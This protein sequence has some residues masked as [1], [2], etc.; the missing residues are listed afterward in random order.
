M[1]AKFFPAI[2]VLLVVSWAASA[3]GYAIRLT[4]STNLRAT[5]SLTGRIVET[6]P[7]GAILQV[8][9]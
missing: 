6:A 1:K 3:R 2:I 4:Y 7:A 9:G 8:L 5:Y